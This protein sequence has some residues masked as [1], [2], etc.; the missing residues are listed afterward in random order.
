M[1]VQGMRGFRCGSSNARPTSR[2]DGNDTVFETIYIFS[3][4]HSRGKAESVRHF[5]SI[6][7]VFLFCFPCLYRRSGSNEERISLLTA[8]G[9]SVRAKRFFRYPEKA[10]EDVVFDLIELERIPIGESFNVVVTLEVY[11]KASATT[12]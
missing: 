10:A 7:N 6:S 11:V 8:V 2:E 1:E 9:S 3:G 12:T 4:Y 5:P